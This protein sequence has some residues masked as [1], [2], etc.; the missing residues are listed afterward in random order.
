[1]PRHFL[2]IF[3]L[4]KTELINLINRTGQLKKEKK[5]SVPHLNLS[6]KSIGMIF[7]KLSTRTRV[8]FQVAIND[9]GANPI[10]LNPNDMQLGRGEIIPDTAK[11]LSSYLDAVIIRTYGQDRIIKFALNSSVPVINAL[12]DLEHPTQIVA[13]LF[14]IQEQG[15]DLGSFNLTYIGDGNNITNS[16][17]AA[18]ALLGYNIT[19][20]C[21]EGYEPDGEI[22]SKSKDLGKNKIVINH[23]PVS[24]VKDS[25]V[26]YT[27]V[28]VSMGQEDDS[29]NKENIFQPYQ[30]NKSLLENSKNNTL[31]MH[32]LPAHRGE[33]ITEEVLTSPNSVVFE[34]AEN[35]LHSG[36]AI[37]EYFIKN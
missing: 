11:V 31:I 2:S 30:I 20:C 29:Q 19:V 14:T 25:D 15:I 28:W 5:D 27:D 37:L 6:G 10:Y 9:L 4:E 33:E 32:C 26:I 24:A 1:M 34:Q 22:L 35:K 21:P 23:E 17:I 7:E 8:S 16:F 12:T 3:D 13:D 36:K 18:S